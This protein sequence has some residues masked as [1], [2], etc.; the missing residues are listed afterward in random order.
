MFSF[1]SGQIKATP[2]KLSFFR[3]LQDWL[4]S[5]H[6]QGWGVFEELQSQ[7]ISSCGC[8]PAGFY[9]YLGCKAASFQG[10]CRAMEKRMGVET[11]K[12]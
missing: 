11:E 8:K 7:S 5:N 12:L 3:E 10:Y 6:A 2:C 9:N 4:N 1:E